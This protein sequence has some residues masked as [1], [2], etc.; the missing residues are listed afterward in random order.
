L[1]LSS[2]LSH[3]FFDPTCRFEKE[4]TPTVVLNVIE[5]NSWE[6]PDPEMLKREWQDHIVKMRDQSIYMLW[7]RA[8]RRKFLN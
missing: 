8:P 1:D 7:Q 2:G 4:N 3:F 6:S 5:Q